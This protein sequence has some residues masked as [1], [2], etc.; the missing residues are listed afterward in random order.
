M[1]LKKSKSNKTERQS[2][3]CTEKEGNKIKQK[4]LLYAG[5]KPN[6]E[7]NVSAYLLYAALNFVP[8][9]EDFED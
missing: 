3:R 5:T 6:G 2:F 1:K 7:P 4:A 8:G 9:R